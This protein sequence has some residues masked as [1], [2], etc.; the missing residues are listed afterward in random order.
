MIDFEIFEPKNEQEV[1]PGT[2]TRAKATCLCCGATLSPD[3]VRA[4]LAAQRGGAD[5]IFD[6]M[7]NRIHGARLLA[8]IK[9]KTG[10]KGRDYRLPIIKD[11]EFIWKAKDKIKELNENPLLSGLNLVPDELIA[12][13]EIR[14]VSVPLYGASSWGSLHRAPKGLFS[15]IYQ[16]SK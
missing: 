11:Y 14:R 1:P 9:N 4:Q 5:V 16:A 15:H 7:G 8:I 13:N 3:R 12:L 2:V 10:K 6:E